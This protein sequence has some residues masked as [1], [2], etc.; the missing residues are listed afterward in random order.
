MSK[1]QAICLS[2]TI[3]GKEISIQTGTLAKQAGGAVTVHIGGSV[4]LTTA[5]VAPTPKVVNFVPLTIEYRE[6]TYAAGKIPGGFFKREARPRDKETLY[7][8]LTDRPI[9]PLFPEGWNHETMVYTL[10]VSSDTK[11]DPGPLSILAG[12]AALMLSDAPFAGP[13][14]G[15]RVAL[16]KGQFV[17]FPTMEERTDCEL[18]IVVAGKKGAILMVEAGAREAAEDQVLKAIEVAQ[19]AIDRLCGLQMRLVAEAE[20]AG[21]KIVKREVAPPQ[22]PEPVHGFV[23]ARALDAIR[24]LLHAGYKLKHEFGDRIKALEGELVEEVQKKAATEPAFVAQEAHV[25]AIV[26]DITA[27]EGRKMILEERMRPDGRGF[28]EVRPITVMV[29]ALPCTHGSAVFTRGETQALATATL[30]TPEDMQ[31]MDE[32]EGEYK[33]RFMLHYNFPAY[34]V[35]EVKPERGPGRREIGHGALAKRALLPLLPGEEQFPYTIRIVSDILESNGSSSMASICG[36]SLAL[37]DAGVPMKAPCAGVAMGL[38]MEGGRH[39]ILTDIAG[40]EDHVGDMDFKVA[41]TRSGVTALQMDIKVDGVSLGIMRE[42]LEQARKGRLVILEKMLAALPSPRPELSPMAPRLIRLQIPVDKIGALIGPGGKN[43]R[44]MIEEYSVNI[45][46]EDDGGVFISGLDAA[47]IGRA[48]AEVESIYKEAEVG[49]IYKGRV[50]SC[51]EFGAFVEIMPGKE[52]LLHISQIDVQR[53][54]KVTDVL[55][56]GD[57]VEVK[58]LEVSREGKIRLSRK[59]VLAP[60]SEGDGPPRDRE[61]RGRPGSGGPRRERSYR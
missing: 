20:K 27:E 24:A 44:R 2:E 3:G 41:G 61:G 57:M 43:I 54:N 19:E 47:A 12:S 49:K 9:R 21:R 35:G 22:F 36:G 33:D 56:E 17:L 29:P 42:A 18:E 13:V 4:I 46:V 52:G 39:V 48:Q 32:L 58:V 15:V 11:N 38:F 14:A 23:R 8:R 34:S 10:V 1:I 50:V 16:I 60:G 45:E 5:T 6:R 25:H 40:L 53:V 59:A 26:H 31:I 7:A 55:K 30:G 51:V 28:D 37:F